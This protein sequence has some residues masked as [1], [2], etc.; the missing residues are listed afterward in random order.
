MSADRSEINRRSA[1]LSWAAT[2][3]AER[4]ERTRPALEAFEKRFEE[5]ADPEGLLSPEERRE[6]AARLRTAH[7]VELG[8]KS[9]AARKP[10]PNACGTYKGWYRHYRR[11]EDPCDACRQAKRAY[12]LSRRKAQS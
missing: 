12:Q 2:T 1:L 11:H 3:D 8:R 4:R 7:Y 6:A 10:K 9:A 5:L